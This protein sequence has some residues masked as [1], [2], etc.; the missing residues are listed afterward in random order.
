MYINIEDVNTNVTIE[1]EDEGRG[2]DS[3]VHIEIEDNAMEE[4]TFAIIEVELLK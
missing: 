2:H 4:E 3:C 1:A